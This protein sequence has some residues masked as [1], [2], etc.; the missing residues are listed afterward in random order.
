MVRSMSPLPLIAVLVAASLA[1]NLPFLRRAGP[2]STPEGDEVPLAEEARDS[3]VEDRKAG[4]GE[5]DEPE[6]GPTESELR[7]PTASPRIGADEQGSQGAASPTSTPTATQTPTIPPTVPT[8]TPIPSDTPRP[9]P[10]PSNTPVPTAVPSN[11]PTATP[12]PTDT[13]KLSP[14]AAP[15]D[16]KRAEWSCDSKEYSLTLV[17]VDRADNEEGFRIYIDGKA[18][19][20][21]VKANV[22]SYKYKPPD[23][24]SHTYAVEAYNQAGT[25][26]R[27]S[28]DD[29]GCLY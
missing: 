14:P 5:V 29:E 16:L 21:P 3:V 17:W 22:T 4:T 11:T 8:A 12:E 23:Y 9:T 15:T 10:K 6:G 28:Y 1:C 2:P 27:S 26:R 20:P 24:R 13:P 25:S 7:S 19:D 18:I